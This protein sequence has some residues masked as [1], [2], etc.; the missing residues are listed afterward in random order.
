[1]AQKPVYQVQQKVLISVD[2]RCCPG[3]QGPDCQDHGKAP[4]SFLLTPD[5][6]NYAVP[7]MSG[8]NTLCFL[9]QIPQ[10]TLSPQSQV[11][12]FRRLGTHWMALNLVR[13]LSGMAE[14]MCLV[15]PSPMGV[16][17]LEN[18][19]LQSVWAS[20]WRC[21]VLCSQIPR[22]FSLLPGANTRPFY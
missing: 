1:M 7:L 20:L 15:L 21:T 2:W 13:C 22:A 12:N 3:F 10:Q 16:P 18:L 8:L 6:R 19:A 4:Q 9:L 11:V 14:F 17:F 5:P